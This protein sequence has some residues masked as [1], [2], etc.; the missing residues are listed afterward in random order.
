MSGLS[1]LVGN[2]DWSAPKA[3]PL[4]Q[5]YRHNY[6]VLSYQASTTEVEQLLGSYTPCR[7]CTGVKSGTVYFD[8]AQKHVYPGCTFS[9]RH[10]IN[11][12][13]TYKVEVEDHDHSVVCDHERTHGL[14]PPMKEF[15]KN[16]LAANP[17]SSPK[18]L[19]ASLRMKFRSV[20]TWVDDPIQADKIYR[21]IVDFKKN[22][23]TRKRKKK[24][25]VDIESMM[26][27]RLG[28]SL[29][30]SRHQTLVRQILIPLQS[31]S[32]TL[33]TQMMAHLASK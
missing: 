14:P 28:I 20:A 8:C 5:Q 19:Y 2:G 33:F 31:F 22:N 21:Q 11:Q 26:A 4:R 10:T 30:N 17:K 6:K 27:E 7:R 16:E 18:M 13:G 1:R 15:L 23:L 29:P 25:P 32:H 9:L 24:E 3:K 12:D